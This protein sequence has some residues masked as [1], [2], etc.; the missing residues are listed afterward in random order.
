MK[1]ILSRMVIGAATLFTTS[2]LLAIEEI[3]ID[4]WSEYSNGSE[5]DVVMQGLI[6]EL[7]WTKKFSLVAASA[8]GMQIEES[9]GEKKSTAKDLAI[10]PKY[11]FFDP[12]Q[13]GMPGFSL[14]AGGVFPTGHNFLSSPNRAYLA[15]AMFPMKLFNDRV[16]LEAQLGH[17]YIDVKDEKDIN[18]LHWGI[19]VEAN[20]VDD[21]NIFTNF[22]SGT[23]FDI[24]VPSLSQE[25]GLSYEYSDTFK[26]KML[27]GIQPELEGRGDADATEYWGE[28]GVEI[29]FSEFD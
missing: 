10:Y 9:S 7:E 14:M 5:F 24:D 20:M 3:T 28:L 19:F 12:K 1:K 27:F 22:Y 8:A 11:D 29:H 17:R 6:M 23:Q 2:N 13:N 4:T 26:Y 25:Y 18:R 15:I 16:A 21:Y